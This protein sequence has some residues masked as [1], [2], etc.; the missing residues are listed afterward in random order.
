MQHQLKLHFPS[1]SMSCLACLGYFFR[2]GGTFF[3]FVFPFEKKTKGD[4]M[5]WEGL[6]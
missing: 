6:R 4:S 3:V 1:S 2:E 5:R